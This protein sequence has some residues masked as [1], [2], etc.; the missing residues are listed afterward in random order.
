MIDEP[1]FRTR[2]K[3]RTPIEG[4]KGMDLAELPACYGA[5][6]VKSAGKISDLK[7]EVRAWSMPEDQS[8]QFVPELMK[9]ASNGCCKFS[10]GG[11]STRDAPEE[12]FPSS[13]FARAPYALG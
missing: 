13:R 11:L 7:P 2:L 1:Q 12:A 10:S 6:Q 9:S 8:G 5:I 3:G 4:L